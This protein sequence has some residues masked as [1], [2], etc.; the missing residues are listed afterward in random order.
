MKKILLQM[1]IMLT[2][3]GNPAC[4]Q[5]QSGDHSHK[6]DR[7]P[8]VAG[9]FYPGDSATLAR[10]LQSFFENAVPPQN[11]GTLR[12]I[13]VP[14]AGYVFSGQVAASGFKQ[15][16]PGADYKRIFIIGSSHTAWFDGA[17]VYAAGSFITPLGAVPVDTAV[18]Q[19]LL[20]SS[21][22]F[23]FDKSVHQTEHSLEV[24]L[25]F[26]QMRLKKPFCIVPIIIGGQSQRTIVDVA[27]ALQPWF[28]DESLFVISSDFSH[29]PKAGDAVKVDHKTANAILSND[30]AVLKK[31][32]SENDDE[33]C[34]G[35]VTSLCGW[36][37]VMTL[38]NLTQKDTS[39]NY[40]SLQYMNSSASP[41]GDSS[42]VVGYNAIA[43]FHKNHDQVM[44]ELSKQ[45]KSQLLKIARNTIREFLSTAK[46]TEIDTT[47]LSPG[48]LQH[49]GAFVTLREDGNLRGCI[50]RFT[51]DQP[52]AQVVAQM[53]IA[54]ATQDHRFNPVTAS[55]LS[56][57]DIEIS[58]LSPMRKIQSVDEIKM[59]VH[60]IYILKCG[61]GGTFLPQVAVETGWSREEF[62]GHCARD[63]AGIGWDGWKTAEIFIYTALVFGEKE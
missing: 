7:I 2:L 19:Q 55:E 59:G 44:F 29:Y 23:V 9:K 60:G 33:G 26:L 46:V 45:E 58:V 11:Q 63:K 6:D 31:I 34:A 38:M 62:L 5:D 61:H 50:G 24:Q 12:A 52:L 35:L 43:V 10:E 14:H 49:C 21:S 27:E 8:A 25:P 56:S 41:Y 22:A 1:I 37:S 20:K 4:S 32:L 54:S 16:N 15:I 3:F 17:S 30:P 47:T 48:L 42:R 51:S 36:T 40:V 53:A 13:I 18:A 28:N 39:Y 57:I